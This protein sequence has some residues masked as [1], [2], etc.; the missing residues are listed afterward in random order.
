[1]NSIQLNSA[2]H[3]VFRNITTSISQLPVKKI[4]II[5]RFYKN[6]RRI[7]KNKMKYKIIY[8]G[9]ELSIKLKCVEIG[10]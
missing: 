6:Q 2:L 8:K 7:S 5:A 4:T 9:S 3:L 1:M 10:K